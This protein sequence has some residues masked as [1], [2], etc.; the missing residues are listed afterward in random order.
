MLVRVFAL[1]LVLLL[2]GTPTHAQERSPAGDTATLEFANKPWTGDLDG[3]H[4][5]R[6]IR[7]LVPYSRT[8]YFIDGATQR[9]I[10]YEYMRQFEDVYNAKAKTG[11]LKVHVVFIP[12]TRDQLIPSLREGLGDVIA[13]NFTVTDA[14]KEIIDFTVPVGRNVAEVIVSHKDAAAPATIEDLAGKRVFVRPGSSYHEHLVELGRDFAAR[15][16]APIEI[17]DAPAQFEDEDVLEMVNAGLVQYTVVDDYIAEQWKKVLPEIRSHRGAVVRQGNEIA[18][19]IRKDSPKFKAEL[20]AFVGTTKRG[21][22]FGNIAYRK[23]FENTKFVRNATAESEIKK[24]NELVALFRRYSEQY[25]VDWLLMAAQGYQESRLDQS[26]RS[27]VG[28]IGVMQVM[29][30][31][32]QDMAVGSITELEANVHAGVKYMRWVI[33]NFFN[34]PQVDAFNRML[35]AFASYNAGPGRVRGLRKTAAERGLDPNVWFNNVEHIAAEKI[36]RETV[37][38]VSNIYKY[39]T[40]YRLVMAEQ[41]RKAQQREALLEKPSGG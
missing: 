2:G 38:Y 33:N 21:T 37:Q 28:A 34:D 29:P 35:F 24:L 4:Q 23:Y 32:G 6:I 39:Y 12:T 18:F 9:G 7:V 1:S 16:L 3:M 17:V 20:D 10:I 27:P 30:A 31:T 40:A 26:V 13:T 19:A 8:F 15:G 41:Q 5:R 22:A 36:G 25:D 11:H 14:R